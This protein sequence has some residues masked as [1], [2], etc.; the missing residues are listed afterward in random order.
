MD[1][2]QRFRRA[3][4]A[5]PGVH[6]VV[7]NVDASVYTVDWP[8]GEVAKPHVPPPKG[9]EVRR[10]PWT[11]VGVAFVV[12]LLGILGVREA[13]R[14]CLASDQRRRLRPL[15]L[16]AVPLLVGLVLVIIERF[17]LLTV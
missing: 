7:D 15:T 16:A 9:V 13:S 6:V 12:M 17:V 3:L 14:A 4:A 8:P 2:G 10:T 1:W 5:A 11:P